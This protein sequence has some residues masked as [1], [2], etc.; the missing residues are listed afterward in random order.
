MVVEESLRI[1]TF[2]QVPSAE[3]FAFHIEP[4]NVPAVFEGC[5]RNWEAF[6]K[7]NPYNG[8]LAYLQQHVGSSVVQV[9]MSRSP[10][11]FYG[12]IRSHERVPIPY[13][14]FIAYCMDHLENKEDGKDNPCQSEEN[15]LK[16]S[17][18]DQ[19]DSCANE[20][21]QYYL[22][23]VPILN[24]ENDD[25]AQLKCLS[26]DIHT[27]EFLQTKSMFSINLWMN[28]A[29]TRSSTHYDIYN[30]LLCVVS[31]CKQVSLW[32]PSAS[33][34]LY[35]L[36][37]YG[38]ASNHSA[39]MLGSPDLSLYP[40][41]KYL[42]EHSQIVVLQAGDALFIPE[43]WYHQVDSEDLTIGVNFWWQSGIMSSV[44]EHMDAYYLRKILKRLTDK[45]LDQRVQQHSLAGNEFAATTS[46][47]PSNAHRDDTDPAGLEQKNMLHNLGS[48][49]L[50]SLR[51][52]VSLVHDHVNQSQPVGCSSNDTQGIESNDQVAI[53][54]EDSSYCLEDQVANLIWSLDPITL[55]NVFY[56]MA[57]NFPR[58]LEALVLHAL[59]PIGAEILTRKFEEVDHLMTVDSRDHFYQ[60]V[61]GVFEDRFAAMDKL[62]NRKESFA[63]QAFKDVLDQYLG[64]NFNDGPQR[65]V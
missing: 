44:L 18:I 48:L 14:T 31:G 33:P 8:G 25:A 13:S 63:C 16:L 19:T 65:Q 53:R 36:P 28:S 39:I 43:G 52:L 38:E 1:Q 11:V 42:E 61:Y 32:P 17:D 23:Q 46:D 55:R 47:L 3:E 10:P 40:R 60:I 51:R 20:V 62:L 29:K 9:M 7:W 34:F 59:S 4:K 56:A 30:N 6:F 26:E 58:T 50:Q 15:R 49:E 54:K 12:D 41:A 45:E 64:V 37:L 2:N 22:A 35:P 57:H 24:A 5:I 27:P 21:Q